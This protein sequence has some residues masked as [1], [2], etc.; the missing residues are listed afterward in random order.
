MFS[1]LSVRPLRTQNTPFFAVHHIAVPGY[2]RLRVGRAT[3]GN[4]CYREFSLGLGEGLGSPAGT[5]F[6]ADIAPPGLEGVTIGLLRNLRRSRHHY[7]S[8]V[9]GRNSPTPP[10]SPG[11]CGW[12]RLSWQRRVSGCC[13]LCV[14]LIDGGRRRPVPAPP[15][16]LTLISPRIGA[17]GQEFPVAPAGSTNVAGCSTLTLSRNAPPMIKSNAAGAQQRGVSE[18]RPEPHRDQI[19]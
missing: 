5:V 4:C 13:C 19:G 10:V 16:P 11:P 15:A 8:H 12:T 7:R 9:T 18:P 3:Y 17:G 2:R 14:K 6:F 1:R